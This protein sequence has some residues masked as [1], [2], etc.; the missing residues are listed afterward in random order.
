MMRTARTR[1]GDFSQRVRRHRP[2]ELLIALAQTSVAMYEQDA[3][4]S[5]RI[6]FPWAIAAA[7]KASIVGGNEH[8][9]RGVTEKD[10]LQICSVYNELDSPLA[11]APLDTSE[12]VGAFLVRTSFEQFRYQQSHFEEISRVGAMFEN[13]DTLPTEILDSALIER[14]L[15]C[16]LERFV[17]AG[18]ILAASTQANAGF[19]DPTWPSLR[20]GAGP[21]EPH[22]SVDTVRQVFEEQFLGSFDQVRADSKKAEQPDIR[23]RHHEFNP[24]VSRPFV[25]L[26]DGRHIAPQPHFVF[27]R[28]S[29]SALYFAAVDALD[30]AQVNA[31]TRD[32]GVVSQEYVGRQLQL[33]P[34]GSVLP[35]IVY[36]GDQ[37]SIDWFVIFDELVVLIE[38]KSTR[39]SHLARMGGNKL[40]A[41][42]QRCIGKAY[43]QV[44]R[45][46]GLLNDGHPSFAA[47]PTDRP[48]IAIV[49]TLEP[50]WGAN[51][52]FLGEFLPEPPIATTVASLRALER[53]VDVLRAVGDPS[54]LLE[55]LAD[56]DRRTWN[57][58]IALPDV[59]TSK[60]PLLAAAWDRLPWPSSRSPTS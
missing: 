59:R 16:S 13:V 54:P 28:L 60:N 52:Q 31:F 41:D 1:Y 50:Y 25:T 34:N 49:A 23:L 44:A 24:L 20:E 38:V 27:Q 6:R 33:I 45:T 10:V 55:V 8:R 5:D 11:S 3:W 48:R 12:T 7:A 29:A 2:S 17:V 26:P 14:L 56:P 4:L 58:E 51:S 42:V 21:I 36:D 9:A 19:F 18:F 32:I 53:L 43:G 39:M 40:E 15:G 35:E 37:R 57:I 47:I 30:K 46:N 22:F